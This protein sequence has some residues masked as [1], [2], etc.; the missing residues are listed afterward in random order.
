MVTGPSV[1]MTESNIHIDAKFGQVV[2]LFQYFKLILRK[3]LV[4]FRANQ[5]LSS[6]GIEA[7]V[8]NKF[9]L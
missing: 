5:N 3:Q 1:L 7:T 4:L 8:L 2:K 6:F 9:Y